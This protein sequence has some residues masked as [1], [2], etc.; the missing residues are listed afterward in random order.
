MNPSYSFF[1]VIIFN[2]FELGEF[3]F[4]SGT[5]DARFLGGV[6]EGGASG[7]H[8]STFATAEAKSLLG[9]L[10]S[11]FRGKLLGEFDRINVHGVGVLGGS[12]GR[13]GKRLESL[14]GPPASLSDLLSTIPLVLGVGCLSVPFVDFVWDGVE[15]HDLLHEQGGDSSSEETDQD[16]MVR[17]A[18]T[19]G[20]AL[21]HR[22]ITLKRGGVLPILLS[23]SMSG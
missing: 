11:F 23:H 10:L 19:G 15:R 17:D 7:R 1:I 8:M 21:E 13:R 6:G 22:D 2:L 12:R 20:V 18:G 16:V 9:A 14:G 4:F 3:L 5:L